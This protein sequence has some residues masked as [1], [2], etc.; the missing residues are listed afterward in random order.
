MHFCDL[1]WQGGWCL[2]RQPAAG[3]IHFFQLVENR[4][5]Y[6]YPRFKNRKEN[7]RECVIISS[8]PHCWKPAVLSC[9]QTEDMHPLDLWEDPEM[10][11]ESW[12]EEQGDP[13]LGLPCST[14]GRNSDALS[15]PHR[16]VVQAIGLVALR[17]CSGCS[18]SCKPHAPNACCLL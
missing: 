11:Q 15:T 13:D 4:G 1:A 17:S 10:L 16:W 5:C 6:F 9:L 2:C 3:N 7:L 12:Q 18:K 8:I 14:L